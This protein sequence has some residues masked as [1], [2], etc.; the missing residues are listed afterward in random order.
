MGR[1][2]PSTGTPANA[3]PF[4]EAPNALQMIYEQPEETVKIGVRFEK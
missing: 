4:E 3:S 2:L 1:G